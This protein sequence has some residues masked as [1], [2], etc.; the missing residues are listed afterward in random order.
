MKKLD[1]LIKVVED[2]KRE[3]QEKGASALKE[4]FSE[5]FKAHPEARSIVWTQYT[6]YFNDGEPCVFGVGDLEL[7]VDDS[8]A[9]APDAYAAY[10][11]E[12]HDHDDTDDNGCYG[13]FADALQNMRNDEHNREAVKRGWNKNTLRD[14]TPQE[15][16]LLSDFHEI[17]V[18][19]GKRV[20]GDI[21]E[22][23]FGDHVR[24]A[25]RADGF[26]TYAYE[27]D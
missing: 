24:V 25:A 1:R 9:V 15:E 13:S 27:H 7:R 20:V 22:I 17:Q 4:L 2:A 14:L 5:F 10:K 12:G 11:A 19:F 21:V 3:I 6:P 26:E 18:A 23:A 16:Q 8:T